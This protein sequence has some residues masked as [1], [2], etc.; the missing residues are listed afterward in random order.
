MTLGE[1]GLL[2]QLFTE[3][4]CLDEIDL[5]FHQFTTFEDFLANFNFQCL[6][7]FPIQNDMHLWRIIS[8]LHIMTTGAEIFCNSQAA[9]KGGMTQPP[10]PHFGQIPLFSSVIPMVCK[11]Q[12]RF[13]QCVTWRVVFTLHID[14]MQ[15]MLC[16]KVQWYVMHYALCT[17]LYSG[18]S[19]LHMQWGKCAMQS[20]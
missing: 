10:F 12:Q 15:I 18:K 2:G 11:L 14:T 7:V 5:L 4:L 1:A 3:D 6:Q 8:C 19:V 17:M 20:K 13:L 16:K 9:W